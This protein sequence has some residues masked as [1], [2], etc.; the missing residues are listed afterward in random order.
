MPWMRPTPRSANCWK[1]FGV[2]SRLLYAQASQRSTTV[3][4]AV[5]PPTRIWMYSIID[6]TAQEVLNT[7]MRLTPV[8]RT[9]GSSWGCQC[10]GKKKSD[11][12]RKKDLR[13]A[14]D[15]IKPFLRN[16]NDEISISVGLATSAQASYRKNLN[17]FFKKWGHKMKN[18]T[19]YQRRCHLHQW[20]DRYQSLVVV[21]LEVLSRWLLV[22]VVVVDGE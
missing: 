11:G 7:H 9:G 5:C 12:K 19:Y 22:V 3:A 14:R 2:M 21:R 16:S 13:D 4:V 15:G 18:L 10:C 8:C 1:S 17:F 20:K 6:Q